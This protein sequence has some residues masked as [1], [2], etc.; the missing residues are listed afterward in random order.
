MTPLH[1]EKKTLD[2]F[3]AAQLKLSEEM[4]EGKVV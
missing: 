4:K 3:E 1:A 2:S